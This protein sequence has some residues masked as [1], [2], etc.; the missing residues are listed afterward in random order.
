MVM[1]WRVGVGDGGKEGRRRRKGKKQPM[2]RKGWITIPDY[3]VHTNGLKG[4]RFFKRSRDK[5][6]HCVGA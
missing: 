3:G 2:M 5:D 1:V 4:T 6:V